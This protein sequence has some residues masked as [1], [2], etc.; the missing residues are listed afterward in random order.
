MK[1]VF[2]LAIASIISTATYAQDFYKQ[3]IASEIQKVKLF[4]TAGQ[5]IHLQEVELKEGRNKLVFTGISV[6][7]DPRSI[8][9]RAGEGSRL[10]SVSTEMDFAAAEISNPRITQLKDSLDDLNDQVQFNNDQIA[11]YQAEEGILNTNR[12]LGGES[13]NLTVQEIQ[14]AADFYRKRTLEIR[15]SLSKLRKENRELS[16]DIENVRYQLVEL[17]YNENQRSNQIIVLLDVAKGG[18]YQSELEYLVTDCG[19]AAAYDLSAKDIDQKVDLIYKAQVYNNTGR[20]WKNIDLTLSTA[21]PRLSAALP[22]LKPWY[23]NYETYARYKKGRME[24]YVPQ[25]T[26]EDYRQQANS[27]LNLAN[28]RTYDNYYLGDEAERRNILQDNSFK[29]QQ[30]VN[31]LSSGVELKQIQISELSTEFEI[32]DHF[33]C[34]SDAKPYTVRVKDY[35]LDA[36][37]SHITIPK[38]DRSAFLLAHITGWQ[39]LDLMPG[40]T[41]VYFGGKYVGVS[42]IDTRNVSDTLSLSFGRDD[43]VMVMR[44]LKNEMNSKSVIGNTKKEAY[45]YEI[46]VRN[47]RSTPVS[48]EVFDQ[49]PIS[50][51]SD[52]TVIVDELSSGKHDQ[53]TGEVSWRLRVNSSETISKEIG[54]TVKYPKNATVS[55]R[56]FRTISSPSF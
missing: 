50:Q 14:D 25:S 24:Y 48:I 53:E 37:F 20:D 34:P 49:I 45:L 43:K 12:D 33:S 23:L 29:L 1:T 56:T 5:M 40:P 51:N 52:I 16:I 18:K 22:E 28:Q 19:W 55:V 9:F 21:D 10:V 8:Q 41:N 3:R 38:L 27:D 47:N 2:F 30:K 42:E 54:Y 26:V 36:T 39:Q 13:K 32:K 11:S 44:K 35:H 7:A 31:P 46:A 15:K 17:N 6:F 4:L